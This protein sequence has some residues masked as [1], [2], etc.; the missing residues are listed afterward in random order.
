MIVRKF[1]SSRVLLPIAGVLAA[2]FL[3]DTAHAVPS[4]ARQ[5][6]LSCVDC[7]MG[8]PALTSRGRMF[9]LNGFTDADDE[10]PQKLPP[11]AVMA[12]PSFTHTAIGQSG[13]EE[14]GFKRNNNFAMSQASIFYSGRLLGPYAKG[15]FGEKVGGFLNKIGTF[16]QVTYDGIGNAWEWDNV[17]FRYSDSGT[18]AGQDVTWGVYMNNNPTLQDL[19]N[20][21][22]AWGYPYSGSGLASTPGA[23]TMIDGAFSQQVGGVGAYA[24][25]A[26]HVYLDVALY[27]TLGTG[28]QKSMGVDPEGE[29][30]ISGVA[31]YWR[32][33]Y[34]NTSGK[35]SYEVGTFG[36]TARTYPGRDKSSGKDRTTDFGIDAQIQDTYGKHSFLA[37]SSLVYEN[38]QLSATKAMGGASS[39]SGHLWTGRLAGE[40]LY[41][42]TY[43]FS[44]GG[45]YT[46]GSKD[47]VLYGDSVNGSPRSD[48][49]VFE[50]NYLPLALSGGP[51]FWK[52]SSLKLSIQYVM[53]AHFNGRQHN[54]DGAGTDASDN[55][56]L[57][58]Q[59]WYN[60]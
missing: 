47:A 7:H 39:S 28:F 42:K 19:W 48:G 10:I 46:G 23:A 29:A 33:A 43:G 54:Y 56:T 21:L 26:R 35:R 13:N 6:G 40:Y 18:V 53:Y 52:A 32:M 8:V 44:M 4:Y 15:L 34:N 60:F 58:L 1:L 3:A 11:F 2:L 59:A 57:Y 14:S 38:Q 51:G 25:I 49:V 22:P 12:E 24:M 37:M 27:R 30:L 17:E 31:P 20:T 45:F 50:L 16:V 9:K 41:D 5:T 55:N 36:M